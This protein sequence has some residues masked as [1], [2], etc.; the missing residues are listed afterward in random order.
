MCV[1][2]LG[3][4]N[5]ILIIKKWG[6]IRLTQLSSMLLMSTFFARVELKDVET[7]SYELYEKLH[8]EMAKQGFNRTFTGAS[9]AVYQLPDATYQGSFI[10][11]TSDVIK[12]AQIAATAVGKSA[13]ILVIQSEDSIVS[14][15]KILKHAPNP[16]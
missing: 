6:L 7:N 12:L 8:V 11:T 1:P 13:G 3:V 10:G 15:L 4:P 2:L 9:D 14:G 16:R 5:Y